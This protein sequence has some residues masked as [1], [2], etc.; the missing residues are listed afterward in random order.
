[1]ISTPNRAQGA[2]ADREPG[3][4]RSGPREEERMKQCVDEL[5][6]LAIELFE[7]QQDAKRKQG[8]DI[9]GEHRHLKFRD[10]PPET[11]AVWDAMAMCAI[12][13]LGNRRRKP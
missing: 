5:R 2:D 8:P 10:L 7:A 4:G 9:W 12:R 13:R 11:V 6:A 3:G 1:M